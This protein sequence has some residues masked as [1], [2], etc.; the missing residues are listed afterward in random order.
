MLN[1]S[2]PH[3]PAKQKLFY[4]HSRCEAERVNKVLADTKA[5]NLDTDVFV[6]GESALTVAL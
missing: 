4:P 5:C 6:S 1:Q 2:C 3:I